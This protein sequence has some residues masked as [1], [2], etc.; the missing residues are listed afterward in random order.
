MGGL[1][2]VR[3][4]PCHIFASSRFIW[5]VSSLYS[6]FFVETDEDKLKTI[7]TSNH[8]ASR[9]CISS[10]LPFNTDCPQDFKID[11]VD[12]DLWRVSSV[13]T[14]AWKEKER[15]LKTLDLG[16]C[17]KEK[18]DDHIMEEDPDI[19]DIEDMRLKGNL[20]YK[21]E[22]NSKEFEEY[23]FS[24]RRKTSSRNKE[25]SSQMKAKKEE[26]KTEK[27][28]TNRENCKNCAASVRMNDNVLT[29]TKK[30]LRVPTYNQLTGPYHEP[31]CLDIYISKS[32][33]RA[34]IVHRVT[35][36]V[37]AVAHSISKDMKFDLISTKDSSACVM[38]GGVL[39]QRAIEDDIYNVI[40][41]PRK[42]EDI[43]GKLKIV[44]QSIVDGGIDVKLKIKRRKHAK[45]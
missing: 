39:A 40:Y 10:V 32:S 15:P 12:P 28:Q 14:E 7:S 20:F 37:V 6:S 30:K 38:V 44:L 11:L 27:P 31:F 1:L 8:H 24:F 43:E 2:I 35:S 34:C 21:L 5:K 9:T 23:N 22:K 41:T 3:R 13:L 19:D 36:K 4:S 45:V 26:P 16:A 42:G 17:G 29:E 25:K 18:E 33:I